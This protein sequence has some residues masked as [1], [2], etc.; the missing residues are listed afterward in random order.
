MEAYNLAEQAVF[1]DKNKIYD[2]A[3]MLYIEVAQ[4]II[5]IFFLYLKIVI[6]K[7]LK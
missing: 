3:C 7:K 4:V 6:I 2:V 1:A 5:I